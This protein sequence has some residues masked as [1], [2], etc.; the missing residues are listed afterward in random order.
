[1][2]MWK[3]KASAILTSCVSLCVC[4]WKTMKKKKN[5]VWRK[6]LFHLTAFSPSSRGAK[7]GMLLPALLSIAF[8]VS[9]IIA[10]LYHPGPTAQG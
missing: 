8:S 4:Q 7:A 10:L 6:G 1:M 5:L 9:I 2:M 3:E